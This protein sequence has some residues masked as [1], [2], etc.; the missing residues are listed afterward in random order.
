M[1]Y[2]D[3]HVHTPFC[4]HGSS[5]SIEAYIEKAI[6]LGLHGLTFTEHAPLPLNF[7]DPVPDQDSAMKVDDME[8]YI[9]TLTRLKKK[10]ANHLSIQ[11]GLEVDY[12]VDFEKE[13]REFLTKWG[14]YLDD[15]IL[16]VHFLRFRDEYF[17]LDFSP[18]MFAQIVDTAGSLQAVYDTYYE[19]VKRSILAN[20]GKYKPKR[21]GHITLVRKF[22]KQ[23][24]SKENNEN[25]ILEILDL[26]KK[27]GYELDYN[28]AGLKKPL[29]KEAY[30]SAWIVNEA[31]KRGIRLVYGS[32]AHSAN[33]LW[34]GYHQ[35]FL[36]EKTTLPIGLQ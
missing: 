7:T 24:P 14:K 5:D 28:S 25:D 26:M 2:F 1:I 36:Y 21:I 35:L 16:S 19:T 6:D 30:P 29:C 15:A 23:F 8:S 10:Y 9:H 18:E 3:G 33:E 20:L 22:Q 4:P 32:D 17:C 12:I 27:N 34:Q 13:T 31:V 11:I